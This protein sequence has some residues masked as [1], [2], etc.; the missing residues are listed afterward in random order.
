MSSAFAHGAMT[1][2]QWCSVPSAKFGAQVIP[3]CLAF[4]TDID[5][6]NTSPVSA[7]LKAMHRISVSTVSLRCEAV[8]NLPV[9]NSP[10]CMPSL[11]QDY[12]ITI[13]Q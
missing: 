11:L 3:Y 12:R 8:A 1:V 9:T 7:C 5:S 10:L 6:G 4:V 2:P 13:N